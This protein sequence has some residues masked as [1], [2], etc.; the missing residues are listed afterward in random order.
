MSNEPF[1]VKDGDFFSMGGLKIFPDEGT[2]EI[3]E[4]VGPSSICVNFTYGGMLYHRHDYGTFAAI[5]P[6]RLRIKIAMSSILRQI[7]REFRKN[8]RLLRQ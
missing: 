8:E 6:R 1:P 3:G 5:I 2:W 7:R 4:Y